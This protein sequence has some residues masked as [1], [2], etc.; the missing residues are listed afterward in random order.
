VERRHLLHKQP[1]TCS[2]KGRDKGAALAKK[3]Y[4]RPSRLAYPASVPFAGTP[5]RDGGLAE[6]DRRLRL[7]VKRDRAA[8]EVLP[9]GFPWGH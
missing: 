5:R 2:H 3:S 9:K 4:P 7:A 6:R 8:G 1:L